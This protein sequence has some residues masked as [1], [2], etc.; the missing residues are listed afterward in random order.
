MRDER[1][2]LASHALR[3]ALS[4]VEQDVHLE[5]Q[6]RFYFAITPKSV[7]LRKVTFG[8]PLCANA[9]PAMRVVAPTSALDSEGPTTANP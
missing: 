5:L 2:G 9:I 8:Q 7:L 3:A 4:R 1:G 6:H